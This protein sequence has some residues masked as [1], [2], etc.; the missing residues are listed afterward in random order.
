MKFPDDIK[1]A[2]RDCILK[3]LWAKDDILNFFRNNSCTP[4]D[5]KCLGDIKDKKRVELVDIMFLHLSSK[6][7]SGLGQ[8]R[9]MLQSLCTWDHFDTYYFEKLAKLDKSE[10]ITSINHLK[11]LQ[12]IRDAKIKDEIRKQEAERVER[13][14]SKLSY[15][16]LKNQFLKLLQGDLTGAKRGYALEEL[17]QNIF[18]LS[19]LET[20]EPFKV[21]GEQIDGAVKFDGEHYIIEAK[22]QEK[23]IANDAVY[24]FTHKV[25]GKMYGRGLFF[26]IHGYSE[27]VVKSLIVG[28]VIKTIFIDGEDLI[29]VL[30][31]L[32]S[33]KNM[34]DTKVKAAQTKGLIYVHP[35]TGQPKI[36]DK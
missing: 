5:L 6:A 36:G 19:A 23:A 26:S 2:M 1:L 12:E 25:E 9:S 24:Q 29:L 30:E 18:K 22:W 13:Q 32:I 31:G 20:T 28:K 7:D 3:L 27:L 14:N 35:L 15:L 4:S 11:Q 33:F 34:L 10:A 21:N 8:F 16:E 17:L